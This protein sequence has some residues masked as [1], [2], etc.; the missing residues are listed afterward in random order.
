[1]PSRASSVSSVSAA[2]L[3]VLY[4]EGILMRSAVWLR[5]IPDV[6]DPVAIVIDISMNW[7]RQQGA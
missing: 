3:A 7:D 5:L 6:P 4:A 1:M 2:P